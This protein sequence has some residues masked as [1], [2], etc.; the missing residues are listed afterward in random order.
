MNLSLVSLLPPLPVFIKRGLLA[1]FWIN[2]GLS[3]LGF[4]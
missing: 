3:I 4:M 1:D 2:V